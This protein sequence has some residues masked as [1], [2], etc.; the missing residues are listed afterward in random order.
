MG[1]GVNGYTFFIL[2]RSCITYKKTSRIKFETR[3]NGTVVA[4][5]DRLTRCTINCTIYRYQA[6]I[7]D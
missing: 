6:K 7:V 4:P 1:G 3:I 5:S 2:L